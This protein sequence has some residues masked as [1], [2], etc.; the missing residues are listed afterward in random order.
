[1]VPDQAYTDYHGI[2]DLTE[3]LIRA[4]AREVTGGLQVGCKSG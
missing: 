3:E 4:A 2:M 1:M